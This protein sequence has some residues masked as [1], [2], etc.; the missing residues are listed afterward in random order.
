MGGGWDHVWGELGGCRRWEQ[1]A[2]P[3]VCRHPVTAL[4]LSLP[5]SF[6]F[7][8]APFQRFCHSF[9]HQTLASTTSGETEMHAFIRSFNILSRQQDTIS[10][11]VMYQDKDAFLLVSH[12]LLQQIFTTSP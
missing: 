10:S 4:S 6:S 2:I 5:P 11:S 8:T 7:F 3:S 9:I 1:G 12:L